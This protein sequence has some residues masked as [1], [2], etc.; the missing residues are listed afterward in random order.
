MSSSETEILKRRLARERAARQQAEQIAEEKTREIFESNRELKKLAGDLEKRVEERTA[1]LETARDEAIEA[2]RAKSGFLANMSHELRTPLNAIIGYSAILKEEAE[3]AGHDMYFDDLDKIQSAGRH[4]LSLINDVLDISKIEA[5]KHEI[6][7]E[8]F[9]VREMVEQVSSTVRP[10]AEKNGNTLAIDCQSEVGVMNS[11]LT[12]VRQTLI[13]LLSN[14]CKFTENGT[15]TTRIRR[16]P[17]ESRDILVFDVM[18]TGIGMTEEQL[19]KVFEAFTQADSSTTRN[20]GG[21]GLGLAITRSFCEL[22]GG[23]VQVHSVYREGSTFTIRL[24]ADAPESAQPA[25]GELETIETEGVEGSARVLVIDDDPVARDLISRYLTRMGYGVVLAQSGEEGLEKAREL[26]PDVITLDVLMPTMDGWTVLGSLRED[27]VVADIPVIVMTI[28]D[29]RNLG[30][31][32]GA[33]DFINKPI[34]QPQLQKVMRKHVPKADRGSVLIVEDDAATRELSRR[35]LSRDGWQVFEAENGRV[36]LDRLPEA[37][38]DLILLDLMM[39]VMDG[40]ELLDKLRYSEEWREIPVV[41]MTAKH[42]TEEDRDR[43]RGGI[44]QLVQKAEEGV[45]SFLPSLTKAVA[46]A[47]RKSRDTKTSSVDA[48]PNAVQ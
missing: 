22:L 32:L 35:V 18:D 43:L 19:A 27:P 8:S 28:L 38:P 33:A 30:F 42:L 47:A 13:N 16:E 11:D 31:S 26:Q 45:E 12:K 39:P 24:P 36:A 7:L 9:D 14:A 5:G 6:F 46:S 21:T 4:L 34:N 1:A 23:D 20:Y 40:F 2:N 10:L 37:K 3:D 41:V 17:G 48:P 25:M 44:E 15:V 29:D